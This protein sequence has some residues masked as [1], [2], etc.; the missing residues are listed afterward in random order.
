[1]FT[2]RGKTFTRF[3]CGWEFIPND[4]CSNRESTLAQVQFSSLSTRINIQLSSFQH[5]FPFQR[6]YV[7]LNCQRG[8][9]ISLI[10]SSYREDNE[11]YLMNYLVVALNQS[12]KS[13]STN[14]ADLNCNIIIYTLDNIGAANNS[15]NRT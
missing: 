12:E 15:A 11:I 7:I 9:K 1:M 5:V 14:P 10:D 8:I 6:E 2:E 4:G 3:Q 13:S